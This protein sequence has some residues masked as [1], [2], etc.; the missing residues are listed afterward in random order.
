MIDKL[1]LINFTTFADLEIDF[2]PGVNVIIGEN[3]TGK[4][5]LLKAAYAICSAHKNMKETDE[6]TNENISKAL[7]SRFINIFKPLDDKLWNLRRTGAGNN[8]AEVITELAM[9]KFLSFS[10]NKNSTSV[11]INENKQ[12]EKYTDTTVFIPT[13]EVLSF[14]A[15]FTSLYEK[16]DLAFDQTYHDICVLLDLPKVRPEVL[17]KESIWSKPI[18]EEIEEICGGTFIFKGGGRVT[19]K[20]GNNEYSSNAM[21]E[22]FRKA[23]MIY[24]LLEIGVINMGNSGTLFWD[25]PE[26]NMN[27]KLMRLF[28][29]LVYA[30]AR[31]GQQVIIATHDYVLLKWF[32][33]LLD[34]DSGNDVRYHVLYKDDMV[35]DYKDSVGIKVKTTDDYLQINPNPIDVAYGYLIN[36]EIENDMGGLGK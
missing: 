5:H 2:C 29:E 12:F 24:R 9:G 18:M 32:D 35:I 23:G 6:K 22:G 26:A 15:G 1:K 30:L 3:G 25:E 16:Y 19:F 21:A 34:E 7:S 14:M 17:E 4:T 11:D 31:N 27:P 8:P 20:Q 33:L 10:F 13:K 36:Q 28:V